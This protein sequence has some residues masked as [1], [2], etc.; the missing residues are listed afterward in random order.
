[1]ARN[2][3]IML[4]EVRRFPCLVSNFSGKAFSFSPLSIR[5]AVGLSH[6]SFYYV[7]VCSLYTH[8]S[9]SFNHKW[10]LNFISFFSAS[11][12]MIMWFLSFVDV[13]YHIDLCILNHLCDPGMNPTWSGCMIFLF[14]LL[15]SVS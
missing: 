12:E 11:I 8:I 13:V 5:L 1:M 9:K 6:N 7:E 4:R 14:V 2:S 15:D 3:N 10:M